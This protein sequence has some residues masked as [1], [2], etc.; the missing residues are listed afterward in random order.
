MDTLFLIGFMGA[1]KT[2]V[3]RALSRQLGRPVVEMDQRIAEQEGMSVSDIFARKGEGYFR[4]CET[5]LLNSFSH[6]EPCVVS[7]GGGVPMREENVAAMRRSGLVVLLT[8]RPEVI[9]RRVKDDH[10]RPLLEGHKDI[11]YIAALMEQR[12]P[13][14][15]AAAD[16][17]VDTSDRTIA[18]ICREVLQQ[19]ALRGQPQ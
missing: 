2:S 9:L 5:A 15:E 8:A 16:I 17:T 3:S 7:C 1:G 10:S 11:A 4:S 13:K 19:A 12:R 6:S 18:E 14:Y